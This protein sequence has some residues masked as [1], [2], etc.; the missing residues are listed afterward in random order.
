MFNQRPFN[1]SIK[2]IM[3]KLVFV[4][5][6]W[7][8]GEMAY[9]QNSIRG[10]IKNSDTMEEL[11]G[12]N[13]ILV[14]TGRGSTSDLDGK[15]EIKNIPPGKYTLRASF[16]G[17]ESF[18]IDLSVPLTE[19]LAISLD[20]SSL[21]TEE[22][23]VYA[24]RA[25][26]R[27]PT[28]F[29]MV[30]KSDIAKL[31]LGQDLPILLNFTP[32]VVS[33]SDAGA[34]VGYTGLRIRGSDQTRINVTV[35]GIPLND[36]ESH[37]VFW[38]NMPDFASSVDNIQI[39]RGVG[40]STNGAATFGA[41]L[42]IQTDSY[43][44]EAFGEVDN[45]FG[46]F[47]TRRHMVK[48]GSGLINNRWAFD[49]RLSQISTD[50]F[51]DRAFSDLRSYFVSGG[52][53]G[54]N[55]VIKLNVFSGKEQ[56][57]QAWEGV[58]E[59]LLETNRTF[60][61]YTYDNQTDNY[62]QDH[63]QLIYTGNLNSNWKANAGLH[64]TYGRGYFEQFRPND[65]LSNYGLEPIQIGGESISRTDIIRRRWLDNDFFG[66]VFSFNYFTDDEKWNLIFGGGANRY[67][68]D[69][70]GEIIWMGTA[71]NTQIR[72]RYYDNTAVKDD[73][74]LY[75]KATVEAS[76]GLFLF[77][78]MQFR[79]IDYSF[80]GV[81]DDRR[82]IEGD[83]QF[84]FFN[85]KL[86][87]SYETGNGETWYASYAVANREPVRNDFTDSQ[88]DRI[89][90]HENLQNIEAG[91]RTQKGNLSYNAN[92][93]YMKYRDQ[94]VLTGQL[95]DVGAYIRENVP[96]SFR[97]GIELDGAYRVSQ[98]F[99]FGANLTVSRNKISEFTEYIDDYAAP[100]FRQEVIVHTNTDI[101]FSPNVIAAAIIDYRPIKNL[102]ISL[103]NKYVG[104][105]FM[106]NTQNDGRKLNA[107]FTNDIR[108]NY[109]LRPRFVKNLEFTLLINNIL[110]QM[111]EPNGYTFS[112]FLPGEGATGR[113]LVT[114]N[115][116]YPQAGT[117]F[118]AGVKV[119]F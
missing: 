67:D 37:G 119:R 47:N 13:I 96:N 110:N 111:Y 42:N 15:F 1:G 56:T 30:D 53:F 2:I 89:P 100:E 55:H 112:Y 118:L 25:S 54:D 41:S 98:K 34:G 16:L 101:A 10:S 60:N 29:K 87:F 45:S 6:F 35:N 63:Y 28:T 11:I 23:M 49:A 73:V 59:A 81:N 8:V 22:F 62:Q 3:K 43:Q 99:T 107:F 5:A 82:D 58:P 76:K 66:G 20:P 48:L 106:D 17:F 24:T 71:G 7:L 84:R 97:A 94:L 103:L 9:G 27:T 83:Y 117:N 64:Y 78:D 18:T 21:L 39:Q 69:H 80:I 102:E 90:K 31:N 92:F 38:V 77:A 70:F 19:E 113:E 86:G 65:R 50:G 46:S 116:F 105:Q 36:A 115:F 79:G 114:E 109:S 51:I 104:D 40:T 91:I 74:N 32:S 4:L 14:G 57:Y 93:F 72:D 26:D 108:L 68:G 61:P 95:N 12:A 85:P 52:Y 75:A 88:V 33:F 44:E